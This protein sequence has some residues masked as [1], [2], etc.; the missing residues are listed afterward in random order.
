MGKG[1]EELC[2]NLHSKV[3]TTKAR[4]GVRETKT[5]I[6]CGLGTFL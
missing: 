2:K 3:L 6:M 1:T 4:I 5:Q